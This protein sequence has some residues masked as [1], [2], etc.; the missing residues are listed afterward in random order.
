MPLECSPWHQAAMPHMFLQNQA[1]IHFR[2]LLGRP[3][4]KSSVFLRRANH[5]LSHTIFLSIKKYRV[6]PW[7]C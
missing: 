2:N 4:L 1:I 5:N 7:Y 6:A 3:L